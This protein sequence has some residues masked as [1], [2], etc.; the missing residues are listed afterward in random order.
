M[1]SEEKKILFGQR[2]EDSF[3]QLKDK[4][5]VLSENID[6]DS[7]FPVR[8][9]KRPRRNKAL[10]DY[11]CRDKSIESPETHFKINFY[12]FILDTAIFKL[13]ERFA[14]LSEHNNNFKFLNDLNSTMDLYQN[15]KLKVCTNLQAKLTDPL[16]NESDVNGFDLLN[17]IEV[18]PGYKII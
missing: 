12:F 9:S 8:S 15:T 14:L 13:E 3:V 5:R 10:F 2:Y 16:T 11:E 6:C 18:L 17:K 1:I 4:A 7:T